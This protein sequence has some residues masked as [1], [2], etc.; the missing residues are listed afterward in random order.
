MSGEKTPSPAPDG[1]G[2]KSGDVSTEEE[3]SPMDRFVQLLIAGVERG[4]GAWTDP[5][6]A[7]AFDA[8]VVA[9]AIQAEGMR[10]EAE[11]RRTT[12]K[13]GGKAGAARRPAKP[14]PATEPGESG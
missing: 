1:K 8:A 12:A 6:E 13:A 14:R 4:E 9:D 5:A 11:G 2:Q 3:V 10:S 7:A